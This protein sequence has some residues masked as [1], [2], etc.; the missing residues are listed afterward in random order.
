MAIKYPLIYN[1]NG[2][3]IRGP[4]RDCLKSMAEGKTIK[5]FHHD[6]PVTDVPVIEVEERFV[7]YKL[8]D[9]TV[10]KVKSVATSILRVDNEYLPDGNPV[11]IV[12]AN[13]VVSVVTSPLNKNQH[14]ENKAN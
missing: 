5:L 3:K 4:S 7:Q 11:Y 8:E 9:G 13:P 2:Y 12:L 14:P 6:I 10:L 1:Q